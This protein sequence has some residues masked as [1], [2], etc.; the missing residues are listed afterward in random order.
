MKKAKSKTQEKEKQLVSHTNNSQLL[1]NNKLSNN[2]QSLF[3]QSIIKSQNN[4]S[5]LLS[6]NIT[7][8]DKP[9]KLIYNPAS[10]GLRFN[11]IISILIL[12]ILLLTITILLSS[13]VSALDNKLLCLTKGQILPY[14][15]CNQVYD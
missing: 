5:Q 12:F 11:L 7:N 15:Q 14:S 13:N 6:N 8:I 3:N 1:F 4:N 2:S 9:N 10:H